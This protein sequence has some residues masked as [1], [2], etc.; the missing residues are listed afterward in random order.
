MEN[1]KQYTKAKDF[2]RLVKVLFI[3][4][5]IYESHGLTIFGKN[6]KISARKRQRRILPM[7]SE[8]TVVLHSR[9]EMYRKYKRR[10]IICAA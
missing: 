8:Q 3:P 2:D 1:Q 7:A 4:I 6:A 9:D 10:C 5:Y